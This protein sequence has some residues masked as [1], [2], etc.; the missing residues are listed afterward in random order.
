MCVTQRHEWK[1]PRRMLPNEVGRTRTGYASSLAVTHGP[2]LDA[3]AANDC[4][5][6]GD[7]GGCG[8]P[9]PTGIR[10]SRLL[11]KTTA[12][13]SKSFLYSDS[14]PTS[15]MFYVRWPYAKTFWTH[16]WRNKWF[17]FFFVARTETQIWHAGLN[18][19]FHICILQLTGDSVSLIVSN[20]S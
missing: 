17:V 8:A 10:A 12:A 6:A 5:S 2:S 18:L 15:V 20:T 16:F 7:V 9:L 1:T 3:V 4:G 14:W 13:R 11:R 19:V